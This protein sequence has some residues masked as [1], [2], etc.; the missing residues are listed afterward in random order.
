MQSKHSKS[1]SVTHRANILPYQQF[2]CFLSVPAPAVYLTPSPWR[3]VHLH[4]PTAGKASTL[5][6]N[7]LLPLRALPL[8]FMPSPLIHLPHISGPLES[9]TVPGFNNLFISQFLASKT[10]PF[11]MHFGSDK[12]SSAYG[13]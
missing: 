9:T 1:L 11:V 12:F 8:M 6:Y 13:T 7:F 5:Q 4:G 10:P 3:R 2:P